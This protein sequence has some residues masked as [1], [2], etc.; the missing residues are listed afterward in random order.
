MT[1]W[2][3]EDCCLCGERASE[4]PALVVRIDN[5]VVG[6]LC[7]DDH[8]V[9]TPDPALSRMFVEWVRNQ[10]PGRTVVVEIPARGYTYTLEP[11]AA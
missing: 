1:A 11:A 9:G 4:D 10:H 6:Y 5:T 3:K 2:N 7:H 8:A